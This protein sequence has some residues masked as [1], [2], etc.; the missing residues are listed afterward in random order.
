RAERDQPVLRTQ[1]PHDAAVH[2]GFGGSDRLA[3]DAGRRGGGSVDLEAFG[4]HV[5]DRRAGVFVGRVFG[6]RVVG[7]EDRRRIDGQV[8][9]APSGD[10]FGAHFV[11]GPGPAH[12][13]FVGDRR[14]RPGPRRRLQPGGHRPAR[15]RGGV[16]EAP[17]FLPRRG[18]R[19]QEVA[20]GG[21]GVCVFL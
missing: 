8:G 14:L 5:V 11:R 1:F 4:V 19:S 16:F 3:R 13:N 12:G 2:V 10:A 15:G 18:Q 20:A 9:L 6:G 17:G 7:W 21:F